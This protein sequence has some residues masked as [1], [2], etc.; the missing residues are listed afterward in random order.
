MAEAY[1]T[2]R[3]AFRLRA[4]WECETE[5]GGGWKIVILLSVSG[6]EARLIEKMAELMQK[7]TA[8]YCRYYG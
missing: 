2:G 1:A 7:E 5:K 3:G 6:A 8:I 4:A